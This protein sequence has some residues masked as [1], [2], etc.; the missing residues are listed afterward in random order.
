MRPIPFSCV[1]CFA[2]PALAHPGAPGHEAGWFTIGF[3]IV[4]IIASA[5]VLGRGL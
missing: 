1:T 4:L 5:I 2:S 3:G